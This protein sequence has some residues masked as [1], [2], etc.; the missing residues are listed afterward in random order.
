MVIHILKGDHI[1]EMTSNTANS[2]MKKKINILLL[3][4]IAFLLS[5]GTRN[6]IAK[7][8]KG[9]MPR[10][11]ETISITFISGGN[12]QKGNVKMI[13]MGKEKEL[14]NLFADEAK[15]NELSGWKYTQGI[16]GES[17]TCIEAN[18][19]GA[20]LSIKAET[21]LDSFFA[22]Y[23]NQWSGAIRIDVSGEES[24]II[25]CYTE[26]RTNTEITRVYPFQRYQT[27]A[28][29]AQII[30]IVLL[31]GLFYYLIYIIRKW[32]KAEDINSQENM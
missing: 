16:V 18:N 25:D 15:K 28:D 10:K 26:G 23:N 32:V 7:Y 12:P 30:I 22:L 17:W 27:I 20:Q 19:E 13:D 3:L 1:G 11:A 5:F 9:I 4:I 14:F 8:L 29:T 31:T 2:K 24:R 6:G 21:D